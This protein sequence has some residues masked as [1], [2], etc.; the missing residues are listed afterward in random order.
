VLTAAE[1]EAGFQPKDGIL[2][3]N[4]GPFQFTL[5]E[6]DTSLIGGSFSCTGTISVHGFQ[7][8]RS[9]EMRLTAKEVRDRTIGRMAFYLENVNPRALY[10]AG[11]FLL[12]LQCESTGKPAFERL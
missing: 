1:L 8:F 2:V 5:E 10:E 4:W 12:N 7:L 6:N 3:Y 11:N 9:W